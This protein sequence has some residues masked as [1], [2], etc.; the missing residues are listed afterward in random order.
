MYKSALLNAEGGENGFG[1]CARQLRYIYAHEA[2]QFTPYCRSYGFL[3][4]NS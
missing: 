3:P 1:P 4:H 2:T